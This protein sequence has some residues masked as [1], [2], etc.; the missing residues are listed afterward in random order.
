MFI[1]VIW[2]QGIWLPEHGYSFTRTP[3]MAGDFMLPLTA[4]FLVAGPIAGYLSDRYG[5]RPFAVGGMLAAS[6]SF[7]LMLLL[8]IN[9]SYPDF[10]ALLLLN[11]LAMGLFASPNRAAVMNS[12]P[13]DQ[14]GQGA[15]MTTTTMNSGMVLSI[16]IFFT[17][18]IVGLAGY[19]PHALYVGLSTHGVP[20]AAA[21]HFSQLPP[22][23]SVFAAFLGYD[24][25]KGLLG[26]SG[27]LK[28]LSPH[29]LAYLTGRSF[30]PRL[31][32]V[33]FS[34]GLH[35]ALT[36][37]L[38]CCLAAATAAALMGKKYVYRVAPVVAAA[39]EAANSTNGSTPHSAMTTVPE[40]DR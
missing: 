25:I 4:G 40:S 14:R 37:A 34:H 24:P 29:Q 32:S 13:P 6:T 38:C 21:H 10:A 28:H 7:A 31:I 20:S 26:P 1:L 2:L 5:S 23:S 15:G 12:L 36:F 11:G 35:E 17:L 3:L 19:L 27:V 39:S 22:T 30:F 33:P 9:F 8:P 18:I 16:G